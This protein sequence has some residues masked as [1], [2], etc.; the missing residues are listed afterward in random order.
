M[1]APRWMK[2]V[3][4]W[5]WRLG[6]PVLA[7]GLVVSTAYLC[8]EQ[9]RK[10]RTRACIANMRNIDA[11]T[12]SSMVDE[13]WL[14][15]T[16][17]AQIPPNYLK[18]PENIYCPCLPGVPYPCSP[19]D[20]DGSKPDVECPARLKDPEKYAEVIVRVAGYSAHFVDIS[21]KTQ[22]NIIQRTVQGI[23]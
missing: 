14:T 1:S 17:S 6:I 16:N 3:T 2:P 4:K 19:T 10:S 13:M 18:N 9:R 8:L 12:H 7:C 5:L 23:G 11:S 22:D 15:V 20:T 21:R